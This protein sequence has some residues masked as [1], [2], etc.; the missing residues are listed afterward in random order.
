MP[1]G[2]IAAP[3]RD[4]HG[5]ARSLLLVQVEDLRARRA[6]DAA[7]ERAA[8]E[9]AAR[10][11]AEALAGRLARV[12]AIT[13]GLDAMVLDEVVQ[14]LC[15]RLHEVLGA[16][17]AAVRV[18]DPGGA[19]VADAER[20]SA[21]ARRPRALRQALADGRGAVELDD[22]TLAV[23]LRAGGE[24]SGRS[25]SRSPTARRRPASAPRSS[26]TRPSARR[27][28]SA[29]RS[30]SSASSTSPRPSSTTSSPRR[31]PSCPAS[32]SPRTSARAGTGSRSAETGTTSSRSRADASGSS[33]ATSRAAASRRRRAW[34]SC[35]A[36]RARTR[37]RATR[38]RR[39]RSG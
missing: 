7:L 39:S 8:A 32:P 20:G 14:E 34:A 37:S 2:V 28:S 5:D 35:A 11:E 22:G 38:R 26:A 33:S 29:G 17:G 3:V 30:C 13:D 10:D 1:V 23:P 4:A 15:R 24:L 18:I 12:A 19:V 36:S 16:R 21:D 6:A 25:P 31:C 9:R 27:S